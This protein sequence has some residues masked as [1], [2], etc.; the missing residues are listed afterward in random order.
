MGKFIVLDM[1]MQFFYMCTGER[2]KA[3]LV[4]SIALQNMI[5]IIFFKFTHNE[6]ELKVVSHTS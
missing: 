3:T 5:E 2:M 1:D 4:K 6:S